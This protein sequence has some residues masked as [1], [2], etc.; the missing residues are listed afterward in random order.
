MPMIVF[1]RAM[2]LAQCALE[3]LNLTLVVD[4]LA[5]GEFQRFQ[6]FFHLFER[7]FQFLNDPV[8]LVDGLGNG[9]LFI[10]LLRLRV[11]PAL[12]MFNA[13]VAFN[14]FGAL[15]ALRPFRAFLLG[16]LNMFTLFRVLRVFRMFSVFLGRALYRLRRR[17]SRRFRVFGV[18]GGGRFAG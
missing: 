7:M 15:M 14:P 18:G 10:L 8:D 11:M 17:F 5:F 9:R 16:V 1:A 3:I 4:F 13:F 12:R 2:K 6:H